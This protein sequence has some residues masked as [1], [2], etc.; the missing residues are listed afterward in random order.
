[1]GYVHLPQFLDRLEM[2]GFHVA[3]QARQTPALARLIRSRVAPPYREPSAAGLVIRD[4]DGLTLYDPAVRDR[5]FQDFEEVPRLLVDTLLFIENRRI[6]DQAGP[7]ENPAVDWPRSAR[8]LGSY[9]G[10][11]LGMDLPLEGGSTLATQ[12]EKYR[13]SPAGRT[14]SPAEKLRQMMGASL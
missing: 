5:V 4:T 11:G 9:V 6:G 7:H 12:L 2:Q 13:H 14:S 10:R 1:R 3:E 8:A